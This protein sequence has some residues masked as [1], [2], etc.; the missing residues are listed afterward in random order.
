MTTAAYIRQITNG[1]LVLVDESP[2]STAVLDTGEYFALLFY[3]SYLSYLHS[4]KQYKGNSNYNEDLEVYDMEVNMQGF[5]E[6]Y[7]LSTDYKK[8]KDDNK[9]R[10]I[11]VTTTDIS[12]CIVLD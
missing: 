11:I 5:E 12:K 2:E 8:I 7:Y 9:G 3:T 4:Y 1:V 10:V 6:G